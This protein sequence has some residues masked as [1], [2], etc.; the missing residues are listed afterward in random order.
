M[1]QTWLRRTRL[2]FVGA[3]GVTIFLGAPLL[4]RADQGKWWNPKE[5]DRKVESRDRGGRDR[6]WGDRH[7]GDQGDRGAWRGRS[8]GDPGGAWRG[9]VTVRD[10]GAWRDRGNGGQGRITYR[11]RRYSGRATWGGYSNWRGAPVRRDV[12]VIRDHRYG[13]G[14]FRARRIYCAPRYWG[15]FVYVRPVRYFIAADACIGGLNIRARIVRPHYLYGCNFCDERFDSYDDYCYHVEHCSHRPGGLQI[16]V[17]NWDDG[18]DSYWDGPYRADDNCD[19]DQ[20]GDYSD[21]Y[22]Y[23]D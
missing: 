6:G 14:Y 12:L 9:R 23:D 19:Y 11:D 1:V 15:R 18:Y 17:S 21:D 5:G 8:G 16:S 7:D 13:G 3:L 20:N 10:R 2:A 22:Y 4:A